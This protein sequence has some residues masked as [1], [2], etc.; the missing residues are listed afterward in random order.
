MQERRCLSIRVGIIRCRWS[1]WGLATVPSILRIAVDRE[2]SVVLHCRGTRFGPWPRNLV[3]NDR[4]QFA[5]KINLNLDP[6]QSSI[7]S[8]SC[9][10]FNGVQKSGDLAVF[11]KLL[12]TI[13]SVVFCVFFLNRIATHSDITETPRC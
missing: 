3:Q 9:N 10:G 5:F 12:N 6:V 8:F 2:I 1:S 7:K 4:N 11:W 13:D